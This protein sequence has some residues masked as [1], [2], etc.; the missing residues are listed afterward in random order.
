M[1]AA[2]PGLPARPGCRSADT[3]RHLSPARRGR[4]N[5]L[6]DCCLVFGPRMSAATARDC[7]FYK[8]KSAPSVA[9]PASAVAALAPL[10]APA[11]GKQSARWD[12]A[13]GF[14]GAVLGSAKKHDSTVHFQVFN[15]QIPLDLD[16]EV[17]H[18]V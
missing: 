7:S 12:E 6:A 9:K 3:R 1:T 16:T 4:G 17:A 8:A 13:R 15:P 10:P 2:L 11:V 14:A 5:W 18:D